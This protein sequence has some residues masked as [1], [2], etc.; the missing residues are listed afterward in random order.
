MLL[1][2]SVVP[3]AL[4]WGGRVSEAFVAALLSAMVIAALRGMPIEDVIGG[5]VEGALLRA[6][7]HDVLPG[8]GRALQ[9]LHVL[10]LRA[11]ALV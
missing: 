7:G 10:R 8:H 4:G 11:P 1:S 2:I 3:V 9:H 5:F 6:P